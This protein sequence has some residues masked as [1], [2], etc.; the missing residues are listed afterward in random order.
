MGQ[1]PE[2]DMKRTNRK[3]QTRNT[4]IDRKC[5]AV[6]REAIAKREYRAAMMGA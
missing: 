6:I 1:K 2:H 5:R 3:S 4:H